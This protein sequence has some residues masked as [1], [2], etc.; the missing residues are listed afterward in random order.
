MELL[1]LADRIADFEPL[2]R[3]A[4]QFGLHGFGRGAEQKRDQVVVP[5]RRGRARQHPRV[6]ECRAQPAEPKDRLCALGLD[7]LERVALVTDQNRLCQRRGNGH[8][9]RDAFCCDLV[10]HDQ[11]LGERVDFARAGLE[12]LRRQAQMIA[13][14]TR[15]HP[16]CDGR[17]DDDNAIGSDDARGFERGSGLARTHAA[18]AP[19]ELAG[20]EKGGV[21]DLVG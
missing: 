8:Q 15:P 14:L 13:R 11:D 1:L 7:A 9:F 20:C 4:A 6:G 19:C 10:G 18:E 5:A 2:D 21:F 17:R 3:Q 16:Q 12:H